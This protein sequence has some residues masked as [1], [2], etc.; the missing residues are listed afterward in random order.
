MDIGPAHNITKSDF[1]GLELTNYEIELVFQ[2]YQAVNSVPHGW[3]FM[4]NFEPQNGF[5]F[6]PLDGT[7]HAIEL[8]VLDRNPGHSGASFAFGLRHVQYVARYGWSSYRNKF[9]RAS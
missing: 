9:A 1:D 2:A 5:M 8:A 3:A 7:G 6:T 4:K